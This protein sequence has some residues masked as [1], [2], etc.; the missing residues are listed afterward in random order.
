[1]LLTHHLLKRTPKEVLRD[2]IC[3]FAQ[4]LLENLVNIQMLLYAEENNR[5]QKHIP[6]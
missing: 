2:K 6:A 4:L 1:M 5:N 3:S